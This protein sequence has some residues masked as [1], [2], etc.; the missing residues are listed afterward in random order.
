MRN[1]SQQPFNGNK[2]RKIDKGGKIQKNH[3][4]FLSIILNILCTQK[5][6]THTRG[7]GFVFGLCFVM[8]GLVS[9]LALQSS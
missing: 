2:N 3:V 4:I 9:F 5:N 7:L 6:H 1:T 8:Q